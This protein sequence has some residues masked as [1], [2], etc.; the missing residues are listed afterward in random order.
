M[1]EHVALGI[2]LAAIVVA[3]IEDVDFTRALKAFV[4][5]IFPLIIAVATDTIDETVLLCRVVVGFG[6]SFQVTTGSLCIQTL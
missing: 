1:V 3:H 5:S 4:N 2:L 6:G